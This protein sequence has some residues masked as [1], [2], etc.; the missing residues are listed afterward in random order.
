M[1]SGSRCL[2]ILLP[3]VLLP[4]HDVIHCCCFCCW[5]WCWRILGSQMHAASREGTRVYTY[6]SSWEDGR[7]GKRS[8][9]AIND[10]NNNSNVTL[11]NLGLLEYVYLHYWQSWPIYVRV[12]YT[13]SRAEHIPAVLQGQTDWLDSISFQFHESFLFSRR[14]KNVLHWK[15]PELHSPISTGGS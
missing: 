14:A 9:S 1:R 4:L 10:K 7:A 6:G 13:Y 12:L 15:L 11:K 2:N 3:Y 5:K 8:S